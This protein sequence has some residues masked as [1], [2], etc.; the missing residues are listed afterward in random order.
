M[1]RAAAID[2]MCRNPT[3]KVTD[4]TE[5]KIHPKAKK[6]YFA[7]RLF[8]KSYNYLTKMSE[9]FHYDSRNENPWPIFLRQDKNLL[10]ARIFYSFDNLL[11]V[12]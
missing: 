1:L 7:I 3:K 10:R 2:I 5:L 9:V 6:V 4:K 11:E 8:A 12:D